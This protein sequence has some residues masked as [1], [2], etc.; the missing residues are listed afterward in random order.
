MLASEASSLLLATIALTTTVKGGWQR[1]YKH[2]VE[3]LREILIF[4]RD[5]MLVLIS[6]NK[7]ELAR[8]TKKSRS[9]YEGK[10]DISL[11]FL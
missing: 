4:L 8:D 11:E 10:L 6:T 9:P 3:S 2:S 7:P 5:S 1:K